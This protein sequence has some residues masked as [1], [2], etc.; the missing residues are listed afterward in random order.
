MKQNDG[1]SVENE[2]TNV[3]TKFRNCPLRIN[4]ALSLFFENGN[5]NPNPNNKNNVVALWDPSRVQ[6]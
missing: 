4:K 5:N 6:K 2:V 1:R 3:Y